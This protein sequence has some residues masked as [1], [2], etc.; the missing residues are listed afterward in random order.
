MNFIKQNT[1]NQ[2]TNPKNNTIL[3]NNQ[4]KKNLRQKSQNILIP[5]VTI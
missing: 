3:T 5:I 4:S 2:K 1:Y